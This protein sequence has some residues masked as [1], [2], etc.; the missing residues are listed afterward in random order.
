M[1]S[2]FFTA[3]SFSPEVI[4]F[5]FSSKLFFVFPCRQLRFVSITTTVIRLSSVTTSGRQRNR[6]VGTPRASW[7]PV[8]QWKSTTYTRFVSTKCITVQCN[9]LCNRNRKFDNTRVCMPVHYSLHNVETQLT[10]ENLS[11]SWIHL[12]YWNNYLW[13]VRP[14]FCCCCCCCCCWLLFSLLLLVNCFVLLL[15]LF[16]WKQM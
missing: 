12:H 8:S 9:R 14:P 7:S 11:M 10:K 15:L 3:C 5:S 4:R 1:F 13:Y 16:S 6:G 2:L